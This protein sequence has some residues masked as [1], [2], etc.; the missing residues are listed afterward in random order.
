MFKWHISLTPIRFCSN[1]SNSSD[2]LDALKLLPP[3]SS[4]CSDDNAKQVTMMRF[5]T[6][7]PA[8]VTEN[9]KMRF[10]E[11][12]GGKTEK[13]KEDILRI[14]I[15]RNQ[16]RIKMLQEQAKEKIGSDDQDNNNNNNH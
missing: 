9:G 3:A 4:A 8:V 7:G 6:L 1:H 14:I 2:D 5:D 13:E 16:Q 10:F 15:P 11:D 12:W